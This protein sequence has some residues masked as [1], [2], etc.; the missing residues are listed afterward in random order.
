MLVHASITEGQFEQF[1][2]GVAV[3]PVTDVWFRKVLLSIKTPA[4]YLRLSAN[5]YVATR[6]TSEVRI[7]PYRMSWHI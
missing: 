6:Q 7:S 3:V 1:A 2:T 5:C 4:S